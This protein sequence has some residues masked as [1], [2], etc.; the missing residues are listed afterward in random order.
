MNKILQN[1]P[2]HPDVHAFPGLIGLIHGIVML[3][4]VL[5]ALALVLDKR[6]KKRFLAFI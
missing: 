5:K 1:P 4:K 2:P 3:N 6:F